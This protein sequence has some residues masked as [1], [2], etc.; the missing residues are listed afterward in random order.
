MNAEPAVYQIRADGVYRNGVPISYP[1]VRAAWPLQD[2]MNRMTGMALEWVW[3]DDDGQ[4]PV[5]EDALR[6]EGDPE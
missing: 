1:V 4:A 6:V 5:E 3:W 2:A